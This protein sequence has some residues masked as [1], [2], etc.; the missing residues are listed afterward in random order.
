M[1]VYIYILLR[2]LLK[3]IHKC[4]KIHKDDVNLPAPKILS[5]KSIDF[6]T[7]TFL[8]SKLSMDSKNYFL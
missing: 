6:Y 8:T 2:Y 3:S 1:R 5:K 4:F 7:I